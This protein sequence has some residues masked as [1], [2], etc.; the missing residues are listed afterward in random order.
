MNL[1]EISLDEIRKLEFDM[2]VDFTD[3]CDR[4]GYT[5]W[6]GGGTLLGAIRHKGFIPWDDDIDI[7]MPREDYEKA[8]K[9]Y[10]HKRYKVESI[11]VDSNS[12]LRYGRLNDTYT[13]LK[14]NYKSECEEC[15]FI[16]VFPIE[17]LPKTYFSQQLMYIVAN[18]LLFCSLASYMT[19]TS[20]NRYKD[21]DAG[22][23]NWR[24]YVRTYIKYLFIMLLGKT[25]S[26]FWASLLDKWAKR[27]SFYNSETV[28]C[29][30]SGP[31]G[32]KE[33]MSYKVFSEKIKVDFEGQKFWGLKYYDEY[34]SKLYG[35]YMK[36]PPKDKQQRHH[37][38]CAYYKE[39]K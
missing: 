11:L 8:L 18:M 36:L 12:W 7:M 20:S 4:N 24:F 33:I 15:V 29:V 6:L 34:L 1:E 31:H 9:S 38:F 39:S 14:S 5:Y 23:L 22:F 17:G 25:K 21:R 30:I 13:T 10:H 27:Y 3:F 16:D 26:S 19:Y 35:D 2:L 37:D 28:G 32:T